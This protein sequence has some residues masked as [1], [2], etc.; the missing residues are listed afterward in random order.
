MS[1]KRRS[2]RVRVEMQCTLHRRSGSPIAAR[3]VDLGPDGMCV[4]TTRPLA[5]DEV[6]SFEVPPRISGRARVLRQQGYDSYAV[7]FETLGDPAREAL[8]ALVS[9]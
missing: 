8:S 9:A 6:L 3:T 5:T 1:D 7:R 2:P 4:A